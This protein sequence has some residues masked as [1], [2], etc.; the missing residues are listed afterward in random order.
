MS[1][2]Q[3]NEPRVEPHRCGRPFEGSVAMFVRTL[4]ALL[5]L[6]ACTLEPLGRIHFREEITSSGRACLVLESAL[7][8]RGAKPTQSTLNLIIVDRSH[9][10]GGA[11]FSLI[12]DSPMG[13]V[14]QQRDDGAQRPSKLAWLRVQVSRKGGAREFSITSSATKPGIDFDL[15]KGNVIVVVIDG[16]WAIQARQHSTRWYD[17]GSPNE[18]VRRARVELAEDVDLSQLLSHDDM[19]KLRLQTNPPTSIDDIQAQAGK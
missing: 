1:A 13:L 10:L 16:Q 5:L 8:Q 12:Q 6:A 4:T 15:E 3:T 9:V 18:L 17:V 7:D 19:R 2:G 14:W 11:K